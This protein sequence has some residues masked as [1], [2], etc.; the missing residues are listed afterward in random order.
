[1]AH[2]AHLS[3]LNARLV[4]NNLIDLKSIIVNN[5]YADMLV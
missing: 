2:G 4:I 3:K 5:G 1:M